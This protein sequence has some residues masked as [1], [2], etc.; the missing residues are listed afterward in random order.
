MAASGGS[1][2]ARLGG[3]GKAH[4][5]TA[6]VAIAVLA[7]LLGMGAGS[8]GQGTLDADLTA[9]RDEARSIQRAADAEVDA[10]EEKVAALTRTNADL[11]RQVTR[12]NARRK[13]PDLV[14]TSRTRAVDLEELYGWVVTVEY[15][16]STM[17]AGTVLAQRPAAGTMMRYGAPYTLVLAKPLP[18]VQDVVGMWRAGALRDLDRW[19]VIVVEEVSTKPP[20]RVIAMTP[21]AGSPLVPGATITITVAKKAPPPPEPV[22]ESSEGSG[23]TPGY[24]PC[25]PPASD[26]DCSGGSGDGPK[27]T[28]YVTVTGDDPYDLDADGDG[29]GCES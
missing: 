13:L 9:A 18:K 28:G 29:A 21:S 17:R 16:Y 20:G 4:P 15:R 11:E 22:V 1:T 24:S 25:L 14:G 6:A 2:F 5:R 26:Y 12:M 10:L 8:S 3:W 19:D 7:F 23:C 27:Y